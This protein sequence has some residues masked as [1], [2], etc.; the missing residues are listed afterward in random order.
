MY[1]VKEGWGPLCKFLEKEIPDVPF[2]HKN[3]QASVSEEIMAENPIAIKNLQIMKQRIYIA[4]GIAAVSFS[5]FLTNYI[6]FS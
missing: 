2:P 4:C 6:S 1:N 5:I 3:K